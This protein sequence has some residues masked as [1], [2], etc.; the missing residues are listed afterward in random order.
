M[1]T[2]RAL[3]PEEIR[4]IVD[5]QLERLRRHLAEQ[6]I[7]LELSSAAKD[8]LAREGYD[9]EFGARPLKRALQ[10]RVQN[11]IADSILKGELAAGDLAVVDF[12]SGLFRL[13]RTSGAAEPA[14]AAR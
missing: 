12:E 4:A 8:E 5:V 3:A 11:L 1:L 9:P 2:Y 14:T 6:E 10:K 7:G 13:T